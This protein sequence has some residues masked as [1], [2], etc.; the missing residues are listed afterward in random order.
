M[1][2]LATLGLC[3]LVAFELATTLAVLGKLRVAQRHI[4]QTGGLPDPL[5]P[6]RGTRVGP[7]R[8]P[9]ADGP[10]GEITNAALRGRTVIIGFFTS[11]C[12][13]CEA[14]CEQIEETPL[15]APLI[16]LVYTEPSDPPAAVSR[17]LRRLAGLAQVAYLDAESQ[18][19]FAFRDDSGFPTLVKLQ[20]GIVVAA[21]HGVAELS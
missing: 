14:V 15:G 3:G 9:L 11:N 16:A 2:T 5:L 8:A 6:P 21:G 19:A 13:Q 17:I 4:E 7:F 18:A 20:D 12:L 10:P 1:I